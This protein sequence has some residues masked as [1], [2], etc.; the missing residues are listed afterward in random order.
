MPATGA[1]EVADACNRAEERRDQL[2]RSRTTMVSSR[3]GP[4]PIAD[5]RVPLIDSSAST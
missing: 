1:L 3:S 2:M 4:T 5:I